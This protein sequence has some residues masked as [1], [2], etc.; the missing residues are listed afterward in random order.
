M[1]AAAA[2]T[3]KPHKGDQ[4]RKRS[5]NKA[6]NARKHWQRGDKHFKR[7]LIQCR[8]SPPAAVSQRRHSPARSPVP[9][10][11][12]SPDYIDRTSGAK[13][14]PTQHTSPIDHFILPCGRDGTPPRV[15][16]RL[17]GSFREEQKTCFNCIRATFSALQTEL[18]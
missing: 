15:N 17:K 9:V 12:S 14:T 7:R 16:N 6:A 1:A 5:A 8:N 10:G 2:E 13:S 11:V 4:P 18:T 3:R